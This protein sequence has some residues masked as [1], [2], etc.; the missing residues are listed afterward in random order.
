M[1][2]KYR[3][4]AE[5]LR[6][7]IN[8]GEW[9]PGTTLPGYTGLTAEYEVGR[10]VIGDALAELEAEGLIS[11]VKRRGIIVRER[12]SRRRVQRG[13]VV[14]RDPARGYV[15]PAAAAPDEPWQVHG[16]PRRE[17][18]PI[19]ERA[20]ELL[21][22]GPGTPVL[23]RRRVTSPTGE[24]PFQ[25]VDT[26]IHPRGVTDAPQVGERDTGPG[27][28]LDRLEDAGHGPISWIEYTRVRMPLPEEARH[29]EMPTAMPIFEIARV[30]TSARTEMP[31]EV[32]ICV[33]PG[34]RAEM[35]SPL[36]RARSAQW[37][38]DAT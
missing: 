34:D 30:G 28:Y 16:R 2:A 37:P 3:E 19:T 21:G 23:R 1:S 12:G 20:A 31:I 25:L 22:L 10:G 7:R 13:A 33:I 6:R 32:T 17:V 14:V 38:R 35:V 18:L 5:D 15:M 8:A 26:W 9:V 11:V 4:I 36:R 29:L 24:P 27:G